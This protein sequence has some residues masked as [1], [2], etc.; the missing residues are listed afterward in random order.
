M[1][2]QD[3][4]IALRES[5]CVPTKREAGELLCEG[6]WSVF[7]LP[8][9]AKYDEG[10]SYRNA[11]R[12]PARWSDMCDW[13][14]SRHESRDVN[15]GLWPA[16][17]AV[18]LLVIDLDGAEA[19]WRFFNDAQAH[20]HVD[21]ELWLRVNT[22]RPD[23]GRHIY[24]AAPDSRGYSNSTH[25]WGGDVRSGRGHVVLP[26]STT[27]HGRYTWVG[28]KL[29]TAPEWVVEGLH[30][31]RSGS[32]GGGAR[33]ADELKAM[34][35]ALSTCEPT[36]YGR[37]AV[38][39]LEGEL[40]DARPGDAKAGRNASLARS[41][42]RAL[43]LALEGSFPAEE[44]VSRLAGV[45]ETLFFDEPDR[46]WAGEVVRCVRSW[47]DMHPDL[48]T[49][50][51]DARAAREWAAGGLA[52]PREAASDTLAASPAESTDSGG[53]AV[54]RVVERAETETSAGR[55]RTRLTRGGGRRRVY[56]WKALD[57][58]K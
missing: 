47:A 28:D 11:T 2:L 7:P 40:R 33:S 3:M 34:L 36:S 52:A 26:P 24:F 39:G 20:G 25:R 5:Q 4:L 38:T 30:A 53:G 44:A 58:N 19:I 8:D 29:Y 31:A 49:E 32:R 12:D 22:T 1:T 50:L 17:C 6:G 18:P 16:G 21:V 56:N 15:I 43:D 54:E 27:G 51:A 23:H 41:V 46:A 9:M 55:V 45:Y 37:A 57:N 48:E 35:A 13:Q 10:L 14:M 42:Y